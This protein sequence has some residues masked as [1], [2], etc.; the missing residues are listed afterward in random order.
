MLHLTQS[1]A[2]FILSIPEIILQGSS[3]GCWVFVRELFGF[4]VCWFLLVVH[5]Q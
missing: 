3:W 4:A 5:F 1:R 2:D